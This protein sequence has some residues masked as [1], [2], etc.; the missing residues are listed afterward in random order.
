M[1]RL[2][3]CLEFSSVCCRC[4]IKQNSKSVFLQRPFQC[5]K[6]LQ[7]KI[8]GWRVLGVMFHLLFLL[9]EWI[10]SDTISTQILCLELLPL[11]QE[12]RPPPFIWD[13]W[14]WEY[15]LGASSMLVCCLALVLLVY[16]QRDKVVRQGG[17][18]H[19]N[20]SFHLPHC[21]SH[22]KCY[23]AWS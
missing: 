17:V 7:T 8:S 1:G 14:D 19:S 10:N 23:S 18:C 11:F 12:Q 3:Q 4:R 2:W 6:P 5:N 20:G 16:L 9:S 21:T 13:R 22:P 15:K